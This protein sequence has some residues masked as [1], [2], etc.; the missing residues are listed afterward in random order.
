VSV[1]DNSAFLSQLIQ[2]VE[3][4]L[5]SK[6]FFNRGTRY[7]AKFTCLVLQLQISYDHAIVVN[8][9]PGYIKMTHFTL[10]SA[11]FSHFS[12]KFAASLLI[13]NLHSLRTAPCGW[14]PCG[15]EVAPTYSYVD[16]RTCLLIVTMLAGCCINFLVDA[17]PL[18]I[19]SQLFNYFASASKLLCL[20]TFLQEVVKIWHSR[21]VCCLVKPMF[22]QCIGFYS[23]F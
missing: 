9:Q 3:S 18:T 16:M 6:L 4:K 20:L 5:F 11:I 12:P 23:P 2:S 15:H 19:D 13:Q 22:Q 17:T 14:G 1:Y 7:G 21:T 8:A 10:F